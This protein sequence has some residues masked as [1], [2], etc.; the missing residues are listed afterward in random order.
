MRRECAMVGIETIEK[1]SKRYSASPGEFIK[2][3]STLAIKEKK[4][5]LRIER[6]EILGRYDV[7]TVKELEEKI[8]DSIV[9][10]HPAWEDLIEVKN[11]EAEI[12]EMEHDLRTLQDA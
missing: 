8:Q 7:T 12:K 6:L 1:L 2:L 10:E 4:R 11:I 9:P 3:G 5:L